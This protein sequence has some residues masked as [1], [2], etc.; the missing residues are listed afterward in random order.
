M[1]KAAIME[2]NPF[3]NGHAYFLSQIPK[4]KDDILIVIISTNIVQRGEFTILNKHDKAKLLLDNY[5]DIVIALP[6]VFANQGGDYFAYYAVEILNRLKIDRLYFGSESA[7]I[8]F[9]KQTQFKRSKDFAQGIYS[10]GNEAFLANDILGVSYLK[11][12]EQ[13]NPSI[14]VE[15]IKRINNNYNDQKIDGEI[16]SA[17]SIRAN[18]D[19]P[20]QIK[21]VMPTYSQQ[22][23]QQINQQNL[24]TL[25]K[26]NLSFAL[27]NEYPIFLSENNQL[28]TR[29]SSLLVKHP[30]VNTISDLANLARDR[31]NSRYKYQRVMINT[32]FLVRQSF[33]FQLDFIHLL[34]FTKLGQKY[35]KHLANPQIV[36]SLKNQDSNLAKLEK[37]MTITYNLLTAQQINHDYLPPII[38]YDKI[39]E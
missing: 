21:K 8:K 23:L 36:T 27:D 31:N 10:S 25:F 15:L 2:V 6:G 9:L 16:A 33:D 3:H 13:I 20:E 1:I 4:Q 29:L 18:L 5:A 22:N 12:I 32:I 35:I 38:N 30:Q 28:L 14:E 34:G 7:D 37:R 26:T 24:F 17:T 39:D 19:Q 11:A